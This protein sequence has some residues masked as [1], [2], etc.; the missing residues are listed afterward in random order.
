MSYLDERVAALTRVLDHAVDLKAHRL[1]GY[2]GNLEFWVGETETLLRAID[3]YPERHERALAGT[4]QFLADLNE[5]ILRGTAQPITSA[6][7]DACPCCGE[8]DPGDR[9]TTTTPA[10]SPKQLAELRQ[11]VLA[12]LKRF[13]LRAW[14]AGLL[15]TEGVRTIEARIGV[16]VL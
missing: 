3:G 2:L 4:R 5:R 9:D 10:H 16:E 11:R 12:S 8:A 15:E 13:L 14:R 7:P 6:I 1:A